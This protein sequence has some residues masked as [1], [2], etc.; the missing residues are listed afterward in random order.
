MTAF[1]PFAPRARAVSRRA[2][3]LLCLA[4]LSGC[5][6]RGFDYDPVYI[7]RVFAQP[8]F[9]IDPAAE[10]FL[11]RME[12]PVEEKAYLMALEDALR[13]SG[14]AA[15]PGGVAPDVVRLEVEMLRITSPSF[16]EDFETLVECYY[17]VTSLK[18]GRVL[19]EGK[20]ASRA[21]S[22]VFTSLLSPDRYADA[23]NKALQDNVE[24]F[25]QTLAAALGGG[26]R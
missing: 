5:A 2:S 24:R 23:R 6:V 10:R 16:G 22:S 3:L 18:S 13:R 8:R 14:L 7:E 4:A 19:F 20:V 12:T 15:Q 11:G 21:A 1:D 26:E 9:A 25:V 17:T